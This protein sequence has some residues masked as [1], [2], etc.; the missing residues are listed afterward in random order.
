MSIVGT[1]Q[2]PLRVAIVGSG[3]AGFYTAAALLKAG[4]KTGRLVTV[5]MLERLPAPFG[6]VRYGV[7]PDHP[8]I[9]QVIDK[10]VNTAQDPAF[11]YLGNVEL[12]K[13]LSVDELAQSHHA[14]VVCTGAA[15]DR[16]LDIPGED[17]WG[18]HAATAFVG[19]YNAHP[20][21]CDCT[22]DLSQEAAVIVGHGNVAVDVCRI[23]AS[24]ADELNHTDIAEHA[25]EA[26]V[27]S[28][29]RDIYMIG[30]RGPTQ[31]KFGHVE[32]RELGG[33]E[34]VDLVVDSKDLILNS[35]SEAEFADRSTRENQKNLRTLKEFSC[36]PI[37]NGGRRLHIRFLES[38]VELGGDEQVNTIVLEKNTLKGEP[39][40]QVA[41]GTGERLELNTGLVFRSIG[42]HGIPITGLPFNARRGIIPNEVGRVLDEHH[43]VV[44]GM[45]TAGWIKRGPVGLIGNN[46]ADATET[47][48]ALLSDVD[49]SDLEI[50]PGGQALLPL[51]AERGVRIVDYTDWEKIDA[52]EIERG[53][54]REKPREKFTRVEDMLA[55]LD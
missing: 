29:I 42:Y 43:H 53:K 11:N 40:H 36:R 39:F 22:F 48:N 9:K 16:R 50:K 26:L 38:P 41:V 1:R 34:D 30:R 13:D 31:A 54:T 18:S 7:A 5:D 33:L 52:V 49:K 55:A 8:K 28:R 45:Y 37:G 24:T 25:L 19:W 6:L 3:P 32:L 35:A 4:R 23:L 27:S 51:L 20:D 47:V 14:V 2:N 12:G 21:F 44:P 15:T 46:R 17:L 10:Y